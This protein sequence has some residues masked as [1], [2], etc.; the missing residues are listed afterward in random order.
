MNSSAPFAG[1]I[2]FDVFL[3]DEDV[4]LA[5]VFVKFNEFESVV[6]DTFQEVPNIGAGEFEDMDVDD[7]V[8]L[9]VLFVDVLVLIKLCIGMGV[10][11]GF[12]R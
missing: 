1:S 6:G 5:I 2:A 8:T 11:I 7:D 4:E 10:P 3:L 9:Q 12:V